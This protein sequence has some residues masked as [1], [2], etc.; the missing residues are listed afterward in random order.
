M[1]VPVSVYVVVERQFFVPLDTPICKNAHPDALAYLPLGD[2]TVWVT[3]VIYEPSNAA[4]FGCIDV[5]DSRRLVR[6]KKTRGY[7]PRL[8]AAS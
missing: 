5:L 3:A 6:C 2:I 1:D 7:L 8:F 4:S